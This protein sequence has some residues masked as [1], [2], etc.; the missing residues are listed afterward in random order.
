MKIAKG[1]RVRL[2]SLSILVAI[3]IISCGRDD[4]VTPVD[5]DAVSEDPTS[6]SVEA[7]PSVETRDLTDVSLPELFAVDLQQGFSL[8]RERLA[9]AE[10]SRARTIVYRD[11]LRYL[12]SP[13]GQLPHIRAQVM[14][15]LVSE[16]VYWRLAGSGLV[17]DTAFFALAM[18][19]VPLDESAKAAL[20]ELH[21]LPPERLLG[22]DIVMLGV[23]EVG[24]FMQVADAILAPVDLDRLLR[25]Y[26]SGQSQRG[27]PSWLQGGQ[28]HALAIKARHGDRQ[29]ID[30]LLAYY[31]RA[32]PGHQANI[33]HYLELV[34][35]PEIQVFLTD[36][37]FSDV[38][39][40]TS[41][42]FRG[43]PLGYYAGGTLIRMLTEFPYPDYLD[44]IETA[45]PHMDEAVATIRQ[46]VLDNVDEE[47]L[48]AAGVR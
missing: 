42:R 29:A 15:L 6:A 12:S 16:H 28:M 25:E 24:D 3:L 17:S 14:N 34:N 7:V 4:A 20:M 22:F 19:E 41:D 10:D 13:E 26:D 39:V 45:G 9:E 37:A 5:S 47:I 11:L 21:T 30:H 32:Y 43:V 18:H 27:M 36:R 40:R 2:L 8:L 48:S 35:Q 31:S 33:Y 38:E 1:V 44:Q 23:H 46:W